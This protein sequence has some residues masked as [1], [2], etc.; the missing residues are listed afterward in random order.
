MYNYFRL[1]SSSHTLNDCRKKRSAQLKSHAM[2]SRHLCRK[3][4]IRSRSAVAFNQSSIQS[5]ICLFKS[6]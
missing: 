1:L 3:I 2:S 6:V 5:F 4:C